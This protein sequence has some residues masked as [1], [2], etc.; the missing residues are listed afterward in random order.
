MAKRVIGR[1][2]NGQGQKEGQCCVRKSKTEVIF[3]I[4]FLSAGSSTGSLH[5]SNDDAVLNVRI[6]QKKSTKAPVAISA[7]LQ[8][9]S[10]LTQAVR[11]IPTPTFS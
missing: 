2:A 8:M 9:R 5:V 11:R 4:L 3:F 6:I 7:T 10:R 1:Y